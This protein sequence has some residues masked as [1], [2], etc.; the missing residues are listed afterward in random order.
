MDR[1]LAIRRALSVC[2]CSLFLLSLLFLLSCRTGIRDSTVWLVYKAS[3]I[4]FVECDEG[5]REE[6]RDRTYRIKCPT[7]PIAAETTHIP[8]N[9]A[10]YRTTTIDFD[11]IFLRIESQSSID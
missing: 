8:L 7:R 10:C 4:F 11:I 2:L 5:E 6:G 3:K 1:L 9:T